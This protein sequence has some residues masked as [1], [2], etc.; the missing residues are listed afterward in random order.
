MKNSINSRISVYENEDCFVIASVVDPRFKSRWCETEKVTECI[1]KM[2]A[3]AAQILPSASIN[4]ETNDETVSSP[5]KNK[6]SDD[7]F[8]FMPSTPSKKKHVSGR[9]GQIENDEYVDETC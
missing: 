4:S 2:K 8:S 3:K 7:L 1:E 5:S 9:T 6:R